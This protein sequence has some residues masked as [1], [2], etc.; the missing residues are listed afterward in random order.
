MVVFAVG[1]V[2]VLLTIGRKNLNE[3]VSEN[4]AIVEKQFDPLVSKH[5]PSMQQDFLALEAIRMFEQNAYD[6]VLMDLELPVMDG[7]ETTRQL[8]K[9]E[10]DVSLTP[11]VGITTYA[12]QKELWDCTGVGFTDFMVSPISPEQAGR[13]ASNGLEN[14]GS[15]QERI[16][17]Q[18]QRRRINR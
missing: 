3:A 10:G 11:I 6:L 2:A 15:R 12:H 1:S 4:S 13:Y 7:V 17:T 14:S 5:V 8:R 18:T 16:V 9:F